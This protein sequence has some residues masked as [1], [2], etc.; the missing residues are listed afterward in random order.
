MFTNIIWVFHV[1]KKMKINL[2]L[3]YI[4]KVDAGKNADPN[5]KDPNEDPGWSK[6]SK[7]CNF[8]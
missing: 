6:C 2:S 5:Y 4:F 3:K 1:H 8:R 7:G